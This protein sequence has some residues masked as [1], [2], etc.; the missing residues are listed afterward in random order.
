MKKRWP[1]GGGPVLGVTERH[2]G[3]QVLACVRVRL[4]PQEGGAQQQQQ[5]QLL[6]DMQ[7]SALWLELTCCQ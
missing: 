5:Q 6:H 7:Y 2:S 4:L 3:G 1:S